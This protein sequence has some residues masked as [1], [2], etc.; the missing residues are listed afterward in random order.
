MKSALLLASLLAWSL[1]LGGC[2]A[3]VIPTYP[4]GATPGALLYSSST[5]TAQSLAIPIDENAS[6]VKSGRAGSGSFFGLIAT[7]DSSVT[8]AMKDADIT[9]IHHVDYKNSMLLFGL[10]FESTT[11]VYGE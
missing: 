8:A 4:G 10:L 5:A 3:V 11:I 7:G 9:K 1:F 6:P 2:A